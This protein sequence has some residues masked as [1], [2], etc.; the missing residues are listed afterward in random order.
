M[1]TNEPQ[2]P[3]EEISKKEDKSEIKPT[4]DEIT[5]VP[6]VPKPLEN[7]EPEKLAVQYDDKVVITGYAKPE[8]YSLNT[9]ESLEKP[10]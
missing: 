7:K 9:G 2:Q 5:K 1:K 8:V 10:R 3:Q 6:E 4:E